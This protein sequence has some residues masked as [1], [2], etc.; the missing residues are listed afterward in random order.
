MSESA[1]NR[2]AIL[3]KTALFADLAENELTYIVERIVS[4]KFRAAKWFFL[5]A[6]L[7]L[8]FG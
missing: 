3:R 1:K 2:T 8:A 5:R 6:I 7:A 4:R